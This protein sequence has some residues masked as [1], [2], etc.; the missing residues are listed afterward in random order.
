MGTSTLVKSI[1]GAV[2]VQVAQVSAYANILTRLQIPLLSEIWSNLSKKFTAPHAQ[3]ID[4]G[5]H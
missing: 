3:D 1:R 4:G 2:A 5:R